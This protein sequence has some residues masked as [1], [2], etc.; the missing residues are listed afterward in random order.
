MTDADEDVRMIQTFKKWR[1]D[2]ENL[3]E[4]TNKGRPLETL[5]AEVYRPVK[6]CDLE[7][8]GEDVS[9]GDDNG[10]EASHKTQASATPAPAEEG[11]RDL[12][13]C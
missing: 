12:L 13:V 7:A 9:V 1:E 6:E 3:F 10:D 2:I 4:A 5:V 8:V 11:L